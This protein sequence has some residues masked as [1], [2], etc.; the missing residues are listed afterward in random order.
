MSDDRQLTQDDI[1][2]LMV[3]FYKIIRRDNMLGPIFAQR[4][5]D[6]NAAWDTHIAH[7][8][9][10]WASIFLRKERFEGNP[11]RKHLNLMNI[12]PEHFTHWLM[13]FHEA[14]TEVLTP[15]QADAILITAKRIAASF[16]M[17]LATNYQ[18]APES[19]NPFE[20]FGVRFP[21]GK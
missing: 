14:A 19:G 21:V 12:T 5:E 11:M 10:F 7:I 20:H 8:G 18:N 16:Q 4:I 17:G 1:D 13:L 2:L 9:K 3:R 15:P 6:D